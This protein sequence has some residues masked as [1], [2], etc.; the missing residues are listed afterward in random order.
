MQRIVKPPLTD[1]SL[2]IVHHFDNR[3]CPVSTLINRIIIR[4]CNLK[5]EKL[6]TGINFKTES[7]KIGKAKTENIT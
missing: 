7:R 3:E 6:D 1:I 5:P 4:A 2:N